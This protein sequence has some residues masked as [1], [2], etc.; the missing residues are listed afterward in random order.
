MENN[1]TP[2]TVPAGAQL[3]GIYPTFGQHVSSTLSLFK[4]YFYEIVGVL[5]VIALASLGQS[6][7]ADMLK[8][9]SES[10]HLST[11]LLFNLLA[12]TIIATVVQFVL[13]YAL[14]A[15]IH[16]RESGL[17]TT[18]TDEALTLTKGIFSLIW[19]SIIGTALSFAG[20]VLFIIPGLLLSAVMY[21]ALTDYIVSGRKGMRAIATAMTLLR[22]K[23]W[24][25][26]GHFLGL[27]VIMVICFFLVAIGLGIVAGSL[28]IPYLA[29]GF[30]ALVSSMV[31]VIV[32]VYVYTW[33]QAL[34][35]AK[36]FELGGNL[37]TAIETTLTHQKKWYYLS[38]LSVL[39]M[40]VLLGSIVLASL[41]TAR[42][43]GLE[44]QRRQQMMV[45]DYQRQIRID[46]MQNQESPADER[47]PLETLDEAR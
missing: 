41:N 31:T 6:I 35:G 14:V 8:S 7:M 17:Q 4:K 33:Y 28:G 25:T 21:L 11:L 37:E 40:P 12:G 44:A 42:M 19:I 29:A 15:Y 47:I 20:S 24:V 39:I 5:V 9:S 45:E 46:M 32:L 26:F 34:V 22:G 27:G 36:K 23:F 13:G 43:K 38:F 18:A 10:D 16:K 1:I 3:V 30:V 2:N